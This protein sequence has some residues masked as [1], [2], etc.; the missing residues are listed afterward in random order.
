MLISFI[1]MQYTDEVSW[2]VPDLIIMGIM[3]MS[4]SFICVFAIRKATK[5][6]Q[7]IAVCFLIVLAFIL[8]LAELAV[9]IFGTLFE[10]K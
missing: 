9:G 10:G 5:R 4:I 7:K 1:A 6:N 3:L 8:V 2:T